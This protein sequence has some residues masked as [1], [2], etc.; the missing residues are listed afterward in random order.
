MDVYASSASLESIYKLSIDG[1]YQEDMLEVDGQTG[2]EI[3][4]TPLA[5]TWE[6]E[7]SPAGSMPG[8]SAV[9]V[10][11]KDQPELPVYISKEEWDGMMRHTGSKPQLG[12]FALEFS[13]LEPGFY[14]VEPEGL[15]VRAGVELTGLEAVWVT[16]WQQ[17]SP[18]SPN[19]VLPA[20]P[21]A[22]AN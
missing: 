3:F 22:A 14:V 21:R 18:T 13:P 9:R 20:W 8:F 12:E 11:V 2:V 1:G 7:V 4:F 19:V 10:E 6:S 5:T 16:F 15:G 17:T